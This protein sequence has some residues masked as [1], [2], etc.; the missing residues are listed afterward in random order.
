LERGRFRP[1]RPSIEQFLP[2]I[3]IHRSSKESRMHPT[4]LPDVSASEQDSEGSEP[5]NRSGS[6]VAPPGF[7]YRWTVCALIFF[8][9]TINYLDRQVLGILAGPLTEEF[10]WSETDYGTIVSWFSLAY[11]VGLMLMGRVMDWIGT[12]RGFSLSIVVWSI[13]AMGHALASSVAGFS[14]ARAMLGLGEAGNFPAAVKTVAH[15]FPKRERALATGIFNAGTNVG[16]ILA[17]I[18]VPFL[19]IT[20][21][22]RSAF[23]VTGVIGF[24]WL[25]FWVIM[26]RAPEVH[27]RV[28]PSELAFI[29]SDP[30]EPA[31]KVAWGRL[32]THRQT[33]AF[34]VGKAM[35]DPVWFFYLFW[36][37]KF[38]DA[39]WGV[40]L[41][42][43]AAP[44]ITIYLV[45]DV[46]SVGGGWLSSRLIGRG[47]SV[48]RGRKT[49]MLVAAVLIVPTALAP[50]TSSM[51]VAV[52]LVSVA[53]A[54][55]QAWSANLFTLVS[56]MF[57]RRA[58][59]SVVGIGGFAGALAGMMAQRATGSLLD[60]T[61]SDY[62][63]IFIFCGFAYVAAW[64]II[65][66]LVPRMEPVKLPADE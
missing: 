32:I 19:A 29:R 4:G 35:T 52:A 25:I 60:A 50:S 62:Q 53:A 58:V 7:G 28:S 20:W 66:A 55:H 9:T 27:P 44:L 54:A 47:W 11:G 48:N 23:I 34:I 42:G 43:L 51:W 61:G 36:L 30:P 17:P 21:G 46:G 24:I 56:D 39:G 49:A 10:G 59:G 26:Y 18:V 64:L 3:P 12:R 33:W 65:H 5:V 37:P 41:T 8:A 22:W 31:G 1:S 14:F 63:I 6:A 38:L 57:P 15:W 45:A 2:P 13:A 16:A 40:A